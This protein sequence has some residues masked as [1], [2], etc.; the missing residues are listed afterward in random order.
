MQAKHS[1]A[2]ADEDEGWFGGILHFDISSGWDISGLLSAPIFSLR[3]SPQ[4]CLKQALDLP[5]DLLRR[6][7]GC[8]QPLA[9]R[10]V[11]CLSAQHAIS[12]LSRPMSQCLVYF[13]QRQC[14]TYSSPTDGGLTLLPGLVGG[15]PA[16]GARLIHR[17]SR[18]TTVAFGFE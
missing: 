5:P 12:L 1:T 2:F 7:S 18:Q 8:L 4:D 6:L 3:S 13:P 10:A 17:R 15:E 9:H 11:L 16:R 14:H